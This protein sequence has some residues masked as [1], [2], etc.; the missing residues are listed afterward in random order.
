MKTFPG[1]SGADL[2]KP[3]VQS[4]NARRGQQG[5]TLLETTVALVVMMIGGLG[6]AAVF[7]YAIRNNTGARDRAAAM[8][9]AQ[10]EVE[11]L[12][13]LSFDNAALAA[14]PNPVT[15]TVTR[16]GRSYAMRTN[17]TDT[18]ATFKTVEIQVTPQS[19]SNPFLSTVTVRT[20][21]AAFTLG[22]YTGGP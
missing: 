11:R 12:R 16:A 20:Q 4:E 1:S 10:Q 9:V 6:I 5:F 14:T 8:A 21:R 2:M 7:T 15:I 22:A 17:I 18:T 13:N 3:N 19:S